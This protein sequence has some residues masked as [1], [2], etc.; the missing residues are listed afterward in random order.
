MTLAATDS[1]RL[2]EKRITIVP[3]QETYTFLIPV[4]M[5]QEVI[6]SSA[7]F[8]TATDIE[9]EVN[10]R[11]V[12]FRLDTLELFSHLVVGAFPKY[13]AIIPTEFKAVADVTTSELVQALRLSSIFSQAGISNVLLE[14]TEDGTLTLS[15]HGSQRGSAKN[16]IYA[17]L[18]EGSE[19]MKVAFNARFLL[20]ACNACNAS[21]VQL[22]F[23]GPMK[24]MLIATE[25][26]F[27]TQLVMP[28]RL[29]V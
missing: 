11:Q 6:R 26:P 7:S 5:V 2:V 3:V 1:F 22:K 18:E 13:Q 25:D 12:L 24:A 4:R 23:S 15:S 10:D 28:I 8:P 17:I 16:A 27:Y 19:A 20:D 9:M 29:D 21:H 14:V